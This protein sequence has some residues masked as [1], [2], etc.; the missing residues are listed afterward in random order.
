MHAKTV[1]IRQ[2]YDLGYRQQDSRLAL[3]SKATQATTT[4]LQSEYDVDTRARLKRRIQNLDALT[5]AINHNP[6]L[7]IEKVLGWGEGA[8]GAE[9]HQGISEYD[10][11]YLVD[12]DGQAFRMQIDSTYR[13]QQ[14]TKQGQTQ[15]GIPVSGLPSVAAS[16]SEHG[17]L[18]GLHLEGQPEGYIYQNYFFSSYSS[19][20]HVAAASEPTHHRKSQQYNPKPKPLEE[21][22]RTV[23]HYQQ[24]HTYRSISA[25]FG[26]IAEKIGANGKEVIPILEATRTSSFAVIKEEKISIPFDTSDEGWPLVAGYNLDV[27]ST[28]PNVTPRAAFLA[29]MTKRTEDWKNKWFFVL[30]NAASGQDL[31]TCDAPEGHPVLQITAD[32]ARRILNNLVTLSV[33]HQKYEEFK[34]SVQKS[35]V[36]LNDEEALRKTKEMIKAEE[37]EAYTALKKD[38][39]WHALLAD[40][41]VASGT[42]V[43]PEELN[44]YIG[45][46]SLEPLELFVH[47]IT[48]A[49]APDR[50]DD[51]LR[52][53]AYQVKTW[54]KVSDRLGICCPECADKEKAKK[55]TPKQPVFI[56]NLQA[57]PA[58]L[59]DVQAANISALHDLES[60]VIYLLSHIATRLTRSEN[61]LVS[62][63]RSTFGTIANRG[64][65]EDFQYASLMIYLLDIRDVIVDYDP[66]G[67]LKAET[68]KLLALI[69]L[70]LTKVGAAVI[71]DANYAQELQTTINRVVLV[72]DTQNMLTAAEKSDYLNLYDVAMKDDEEWQN[73][74]RSYQMDY[75]EKATTRDLSRPLFVALTDLVRPLPVVVLNGD[76]GSGKTTLSRQAVSRPGSIF[77]IYN[78]ITPGDDSS[79]DPI[80][81][82][83]LST[84]T[85]AKGAF[86]SFDGLGLTMEVVEAE[87]AYAKKETNPTQMTSQETGCLCCTNRLGFAHR[88]GEVARGLKGWGST[89]IWTEITG[90]GD[91]SGAAGIAFWPGRA[92][93][94]SLVATLNP[95]DARWESMPD[96]NSSED[97][98]AYASRVA[99][100]F[101]DSD[102]MTLGTDDHRLRKRQQILWSQ[103]SLATHYFINIRTPDGA[104][105]VGGKDPQ[106]QIASKMERLIAAKLHAE[107]RTGQAHILRVSF[108]VKQQYDDTW[109]PL[110]A[111]RIL[112]NGT[113]FAFSA[114]EKDMGASEAV[115]S[116]M[117]PKSMKITVPLDKWKIFCDQ[118]KSM[119]ATGHVRQLDR[120]KGYIKVD[121]P[122]GMAVAAFKRQVALGLHD[123]AMHDTDG[124]VLIK[125][126]ALGGTA[127]MIGG[128]LYP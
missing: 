44:Q 89:A 127:V 85:I 78:D 31:F 57:A 92:Y 22:L 15:Q 58:V 33:D 53:F 96:Q 112:N 47:A 6:G 75:Y 126:E 54:S 14:E 117:E 115:V 91:G 71:G 62:G 61:L 55:T 35:W 76:L 3:I 27:E 50:A 39:K 59:P 37:K 30:L 88:V 51:F 10:T 82:K 69:K 87:K 20:H 11:F 8:T 32:V 72:L 60:P 109:K 124:G 103:L 83:H 105:P 98:G 94:H 125:V 95:S 106:M 19:A 40:S 42:A 107:N 68:D 29:R 56:D 16:L 102:S 5:V 123:V 116:G 84:W 63:I 74:I 77:E 120:L 48:Q 73:Y 2:P 113:P 9:P 111:M 26:K 67:L 17:R 114:L 90:I 43:D 24:D 25:I 79:T 110:D 64:F 119:T 7:K 36:F 34:Q 101:A 70:C 38:Q 28:I 80:S 1:A 81:P 23:A 122:T 97:V 65:P 93:I 4:R 121:A 52:A 49:V 13:I 45:W 99:Q 104:L 100:F 41:L 108:K 21:F 12:G 118:I 18:Y 128:V 46:A 86:T 66:K